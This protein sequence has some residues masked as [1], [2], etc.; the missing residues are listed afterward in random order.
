MALKT[1]IFAVTGNPVLHSKSPAFFNAAFQ[2]LSID[3]VYTRLAAWSARD[4]VE[5]IR[6]IGLAGVNI[7]SPFKEEIIP[8]LDETDGDAQHIGAVNTVVAKDGKLTG[9]NTDHLGVCHAFL[10]NGISLFGKKAVVLG[11]GGAAKAAVFGLTQEGARVVICN[12]TLNKALQMALDFGCR[13]VPLGSLEDEL[14]DADILVACLPYLEGRIVN[15]SALTQRLT[16]L[17][18]NYGTESHLSQDAR[19]RGCNV[20]DGREWLL[21]QGVESFIRLT[22]LGA[23]LG[24]MRKALYDQPIGKKNS[25]A[26]IGFMGT[27]KTSVAGHLGRLMGRTVLDMDRTIEEKT[28]R[29]IQDI[30]ALSGEPGFRAVEK[31]VVR[32]IARV[33]GGVIA[34]GGGVVVDAENV[35]TLKENGVVVW[36]WADEGT[37]LKRV[38]DGKGRPLLAG[39][40]RDF[41]VG[42]LL[43]GRRH[44]YAQAS[45]LIVRTD[46]K[47]VQEI[48]ERIGHEYDMYF[49]N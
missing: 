3:A 4:I 41:T 18:A 46:G 30:F 34:C 45:D 33:S 31:D 43:E 25:V 13:A 38:G 9:C 37:I 16:V 7:T 14:R 20:I 6:A 29:S 27:G 2:E 8:F 32:Q 35:V 42:R 39:E 11:A 5:G 21:F 24:T 28:G 19:L 22:G 40:G 15:P 12:R 17:D 47:E 23:P 44:R 26:L 36:L 48:A 1:A 49:A 10:R